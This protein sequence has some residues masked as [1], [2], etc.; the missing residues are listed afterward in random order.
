MIVIYILGLA[1]LPL[2]FWTVVIGPFM[3]WSDRCDRKERDAIYRSLN[4]AENRARINSL[5]LTF[6]DTDIPLKTTRLR[7]DTKNFSDESGSHRRPEE[8]KWVRTKENLT[9]MSGLWEDKTLTVS[10][11]PKGAVVRYMG[12]NE[13]EGYLYDVSEYCNEYRYIG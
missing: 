11:V 9:L 12:G 2:V 10:I 13:E 5:R 6:E 8:G 4:E 7:V 1:A 3:W